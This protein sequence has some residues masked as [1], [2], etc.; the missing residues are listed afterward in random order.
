MTY[1]QFTDFITVP[2]EDGC[3]FRFYQFRDARVGAR[4]EDGYLVVHYLYRAS[5]EGNVNPVENP[6]STG[7]LDDFTE[8]AEL[9]ALE[10][11]LKGVMIDEIVNGFL[12]DAFVRRGYR[13]I[14]NKNDIYTV[15]KHTSQIS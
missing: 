5:R 1:C 8:T 11:G 14:E 7:F 10:R 13:I 3:Y 12:P 9:I 4:E 2:P 15:V 6:T